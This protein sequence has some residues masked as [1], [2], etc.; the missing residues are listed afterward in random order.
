MRAEAAARYSVPS[1]PR[2]QRMSSKRKGASASADQFSF[3]VERAVQGGWWLAGHRVAVGAIH[4]HEPAA[5]RP[6]A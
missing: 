6:R 5:D 2:L 3:H 4:M 1:A